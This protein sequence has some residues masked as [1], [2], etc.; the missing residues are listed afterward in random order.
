MN[1]FEEYIKQGEPQ[2]KEKGYACS[3]IIITN[4]SKCKNAKR[5]RSKVQNLHFGRNCTLEEIAVLNFLRE[6]PKATQKE[7]AAHV[8][9][10]ERTIKTITVNLTEKGIIE[11]KNGKR[12]G[13]WEIIA[14]DC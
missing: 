5:N 14:S 8:G 10:S 1:D 2:K 13:F 9:K 6:H 7:I 3:R 12:N 4:F 11:R